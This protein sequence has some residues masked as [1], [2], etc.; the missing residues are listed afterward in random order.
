M[1]SAGL[2]GAGFMLGPFRV[3][4]T[5]QEWP[6]IHDHMVALG[7]RVSFVVR[8]PDAR[9]AR[10]VIERA[11]AMVMDVHATM[12]L[13]DESPL[14]H[15][16]RRAAQGGITVPASM[17]AVLQA[18]VNVHR[19]SGGVFDPTIQGVRGGMNHLELDAPNR[20]VRFHHRD[21]SIDLNGI[22]KGYAVDVAAGH[23]RASGIEH[24]IINAG[25][26]LYAAGTSGDGEGGWP[27][28]LGMSAG[29][30]P[31]RAQWR[32]S[33]RAIATSGNIHR[34][35][36]PAGDPIPHLVDP[37]TGMAVQQYETSTVLADSTMEADAWST[38][39]FV[40]DPEQMRQRIAASPQ[41]EALCVE[42]SV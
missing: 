13:H 5:R 2:L 3:A 42:A 34:D 11:M 7:T 25:G 6:L 40:G 9:H 35:R 39:L 27:I 41:L 36:D 30:N 26:D 31:K 1:G 14:T 12:T 32:L 23:L 4:L 8:H 38:A 19:A 29:W 15:L 22:A 18:G 10:T 33:D 24:F 28:H 16:N 20:T 37:R 17:V 21:V